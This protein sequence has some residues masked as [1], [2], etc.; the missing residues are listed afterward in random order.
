MK[1]KWNKMSTS[2]KNTLEIVIA[3]LFLSLFLGFRLYSN[4]NESRNKAEYSKEAH[5]VTNESRYYTVIGCIEKYLSVVQNGNKADILIILSD[6]YKS[7]YDINSNNLN[8]YIPHLDKDKM[9]SYV[10]REM[11]EKRI[12][13]NVVEYYVNGAINEN[14]M[15]EVQNGKDYNFTVVLYENE[16][17]F[18]IVPGVNL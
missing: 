9:Y 11:Y 13:K 10:G 12:S 6:D 16:F 7:T 3:L 2:K 18:S 14:V 4:Y 5:L 17:L 8:N 1:K 15:D